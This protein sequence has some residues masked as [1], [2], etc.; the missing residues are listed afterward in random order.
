MV[1]AQDLY[2]RACEGDEP[3]P[4]QLVPW[5]LDRLEQLVDHEEFTD[6]R[7]VAALYLLEKYL[8]R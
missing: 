5:R 1:V 3:E 2:P 7:S 6:A 8:Q 4:L